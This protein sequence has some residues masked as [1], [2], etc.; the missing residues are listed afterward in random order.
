[1]VLQLWGW[2]ERLKLTMNKL[3]VKCCVGPWTET[4]SMKGPIQ[5]KIVNNV[6]QLKSSAFM[7]HVC[8]IGTGSFPVIL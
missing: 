2:G 5:W 7:F 3:V 8:C 1:M 4:E 6:Q